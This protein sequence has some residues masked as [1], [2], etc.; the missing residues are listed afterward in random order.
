MLKRY[1]VV[2]LQQAHEFLKEQFRLENQSSFSFR[3]EK[4]PSTYLEYDYSCF[5]E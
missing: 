3:F 1:K 2:M 4:K 5:N